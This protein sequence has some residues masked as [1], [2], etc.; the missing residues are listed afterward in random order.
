[1]ET[2]EAGRYID[3]EIGDIKNNHWLLTST[4]HI[5]LIALT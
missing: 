5:T 3:F 4:K 2:Y 1:M